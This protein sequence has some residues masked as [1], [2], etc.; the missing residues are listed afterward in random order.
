[1]TTT[2]NPITLDDLAGL[3]ADVAGLEDAHHAAVTRR[4]QAVVTAVN[5]GQ[6]VTAVA[7]AVGLSRTRVAQ[8]VANAS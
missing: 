2:I 7:Q 1:M 4:D 8:I 5:Q 6:Q 3:A